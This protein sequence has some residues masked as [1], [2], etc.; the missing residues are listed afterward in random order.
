MLSVLMVA[1]LSFCSVSGDANQIKSDTNSGNNGVSL[2][3]ET[4]YQPNA[5]IQYGTYDVGWWYDG[6]VGRHQ[7]VSIDSSEYLGVV[8][9]QKLSKTYNPTILKNF[10]FEDTVSTV[11]ETTISTTI[12]TS[13]T[14]TSTLGVKMG[15]SGVAVS[16]EYA[17]S[18][19]YEIENTY[20]YSYSTAESLTVKYEV[21][22]DKVGANHFYLAYAAYV[23][24]VKC[25]QWQYDNWWWGNYEVDNS[26]STFYTYITFEPFVTI[27]LTNGTIFE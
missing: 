4:S 24:K 3:Q 11:T 27:A 9:I 15:M 1:F 16:G 13:S 19:T 14:I 2:A 7:M 8:Q 23:Y 22:K 17:I 5:N 6:V 10:S 21:D 26:R 25:Q 12:S 20:T 18:Q